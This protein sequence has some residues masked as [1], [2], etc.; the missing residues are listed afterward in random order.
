MIITTGC[1]RV[2]E[3][4]AEIAVALRDAS[5]GRPDQHYYDEAMRLRDE[6]LA[7]AGAS[8]IELRRDGKRYGDRTWLIAGG[9]ETGAVNGAL[10]ELSRVQPQSW[11]WAMRYEGWSVVRVDADG[12][13]SSRMGYSGG[14]VPQP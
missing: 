8:R 12:S 13:V 2:D 11:D 6:I 1:P 5:P 10:E 7:G 4:T 3:A 14:W 9:D